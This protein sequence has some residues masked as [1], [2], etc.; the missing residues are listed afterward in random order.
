MHS[1]ESSSAAPLRRPVGVGCR[2]GSYA[3]L[4]AV[5]ARAQGRGGIVRAG[6]VWQRGPQH[7]GA[8][9]AGAGSRRS[10]L[11]VLI[12]PLRPT[13][14]LECDSGELRARRQHALAMRNGEEGFAGLER[15]EGQP[16]RTH[17]LLRGRFGVS[18]VQR[19]RG[20]VGEESARHRRPA[21]V[22]RPL[23]SQAPGKGEQILGARPN[24]RLAPAVLADNPLDGIGEL[25]APGR[26]D[27]LRRAQP[28]LGAGLPV[29]ALHE[30]LVEAIALPP[31][32]QLLPEA[33]RE[34]A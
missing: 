7:P 19:A 26:R 13:P 4:R 17:R 32:P 20:A 1:R 10:G 5:P 34:G 8:P 6:A 2:G 29:A 21:N 31:R 12:V 16:C 23:V 15:I 24:G 28:Q 14:G 33:R 3:A 25:D 30:A 18:G 27:E 22:D 9:L 11:L